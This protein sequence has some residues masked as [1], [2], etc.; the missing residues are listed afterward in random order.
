MANRLCLIT[1]PSPFLLD[2]RVFMHIGILKVASALESK[3]HKI[4]FLDLAGVEECEEVI[5][6]YVKQNPEVV[7]FGLT[8]TTPQIPASV[9]ISKYIRKY[10]PLSKII[11]GGTHP[12]LMHSAMKKEK[13]SGRATEDIAALQ[14]HF[15]VLVAGDGEKAI[16]DA[17]VLDK[18]IVDADLPK[19]ELF[20]TNDELTALPF[21]A[22]H[23]VDVDSYHYNI[24]GENATSIICQLGCP[25]K[26]TFCGG[27][28][29]PFLR[30]I[31]S[32]TSD[33]VVAEIRYLHETYG[34]TGFM[35]YDDELNVSKEWE[36]LLEKLVQTQKELGVK[37][38]LRGFVK[39]ELFTQRQADL[40]YAAGFRWLLTGFESGDE[41]ILV[42]IEKNADVAANTRCIEYAK[43]AGLKVKALMSIGHAG[44]SK[45][46]IENT[47][48]W[49]LDTKPEDF[50]CTIITTYPGSPYFDDAILEGD[51]YVYKQPRTGDKLYQKDLDYLNE[52]DYYKGDPAGGY[53][54][55][56]W[57]DHI[58]AEDLVKERD[59]L[60]QEVRD[61]L[62]IP[63]NPAG[64]FVKFEHSMGQGQLPGSILRTNY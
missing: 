33:S 3:G 40:M 38:K 6:T 41:H 37:F 62:N 20:L 16:F 18:G 64:G 47:K 15:D 11:L 21:P 14:T 48:Q 61:T 1:P 2:E 57:T 58:S 9:K 5:K 42:N 39:A 60:E 36:T 32:R 55:Y 49:L 53:R 13:G 35:F 24:E 22:R 17:L 27:R 54:S 34:F 19:G 10:A 51:H 46:S 45:E 63:F 7:T 26:C 28:N 23:L 44:E 59:K 8:A 4:D 56:V 30:R 12:S 29:S 50:D 43:N 31:R 25:F 52:P